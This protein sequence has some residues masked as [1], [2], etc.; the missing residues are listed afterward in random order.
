MF[1]GKFRALIF[2]SLLDRLLV[3]ILPLILNLGK[4]QILCLIPFALI[5]L[6]LP[7]ASKPGS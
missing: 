3:L 5:E 6:D 7:L 1:N 2:Y 4:K